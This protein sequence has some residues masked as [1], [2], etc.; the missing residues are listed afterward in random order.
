MNKKALTEAD[1]RTKF[2]T[3]ALV[4]T[5]G[6]KWN[7]MT[8]IREEA[9]F[10]KGRVIVRGKTVIRSHDHVLAQ[11]LDVV[12]GAMAFRL[13]DRH[14]EIPKGEKRRG[15]RTVAKERLYKAILV[16]IRKLKPGFNI[17]ISTGTAGEADQRWHAP[18]L[19]WRFMP[20]EVEYRG[21]L[22]KRKKK[23]GPT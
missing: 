7:L 21:E 15:K 9:Y 4:G 23:N 18:Y 10:T 13:N 22:T 14:K 12:L 6:E 19:H 20:S 11:C 3:P 17:G 1:I 2:I 8:Q 16:D 5:G